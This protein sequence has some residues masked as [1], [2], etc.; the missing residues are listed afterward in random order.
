MGEE[1]KNPA[2]VAGINRRRDQAMHFNG[3]AS[4]VVLVGLSRLNV[5]ATV[6]GRAFNLRSILKFIKCCSPKG[7]GCKRSTLFHQLHWD[8]GTYV[9]ITAGLAV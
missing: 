3:Q 7:P 5:S 8:N 9:A 6:Q 4:S 1:P 2:M